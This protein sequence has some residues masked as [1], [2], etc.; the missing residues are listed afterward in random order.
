MKILTIGCLAAF[1]AGA[2]LTGAAMAQTACG[3]RD[4]VVER[5]A[6][7][8]GEAR[9]S[10]GVTVNGAVVETFANLESGS[11]TITLTMPDGIACMV[12]SGAAFERLDEDLVPTGLRL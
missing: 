10:I 12:A 7:R 4:L 5:L 6:E 9:Q 8:Y 2:G 11:W 1:L 3:P